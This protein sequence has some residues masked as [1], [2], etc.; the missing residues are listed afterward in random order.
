MLGYLDLMAEVVD[1][2]ETPQFVQF[3]QKFDKKLRKNVVKRCVVSPL[4]EKVLF[5]PAE[6]SE[7][8]DFTLKAVLE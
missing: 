8:Q 4:A 7:K 6:E 1:Y 3:F 5:Q 2:V